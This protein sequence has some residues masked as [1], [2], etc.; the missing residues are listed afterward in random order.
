MPIAA[1]YSTT[2]KLFC[3]KMSAHLNNAILSYQGYSQM[4]IIYYFFKI[5]PIEVGIILT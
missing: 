5:L 1:A 4:Q 3:V 2:M